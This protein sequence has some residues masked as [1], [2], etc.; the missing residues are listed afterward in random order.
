V[1]SSKSLFTLG[2][3]LA[4][5]AFSFGLAVCAQAQTLTYLAAFNGT[6]GAGPYAS[7]VQ[8]TVRKLLW[9]SRARHFEGR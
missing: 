3:A 6:N 2:L 9:R 4:C 7:M 5:V 8:A 1:K